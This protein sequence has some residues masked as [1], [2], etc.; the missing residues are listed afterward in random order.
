MMVDRLMHVLARKH[1]A[2]ILAMHQ[3]QCKR[4]GSA[5]VFPRAL[6]RHSSS[7]QFRQTSHQRQPQANT[8][9]AASIGSIRLTKRVKQRWQKM[10]WNAFA[11]VLYLYAGCICVT[12]CG[13][14]NQSIFRRKFDGVIEQVP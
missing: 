2:R 5:H 13:E 6:H 4:K 11:V 12:E 8:R 3:W 7:V 1:I 9:G 14:T 10:F